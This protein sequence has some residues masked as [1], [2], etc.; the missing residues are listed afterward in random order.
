MI[1]KQD[2]WCPNCRVMRTEWK[3]PASGLKKKRM[4]PGDPWPKIEPIC[5]EA[6]DMC[7]D[8]GTQLKGRI[9][10]RL[11]EYGKPEKMV[12]VKEL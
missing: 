1:I 5:V 3:V 8:C 6:V 11:D 7:N 10:I 12:C 9:V 2:H 4:L